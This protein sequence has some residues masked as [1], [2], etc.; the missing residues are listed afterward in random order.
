VA[1]ERRDPKV[2]AL[3]EI[4]ARNR[5][6]MVLPS[7]VL[8]QVWRDG[9]RQV[10][11]ARALRNPGMVE[12]PLHH[13]DAKAVGEMLRASGTTDVVDAHVAVLAGRL[14]AAV[15]TSD[16]DDI[17]RLDSGLPLILV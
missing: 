7:T 12:A 6:E 3:M 15:I 9:S 13:G 5:I 2:A 4:A 16:P 14:R 10:L 1:H 11:L 8:A 17:S